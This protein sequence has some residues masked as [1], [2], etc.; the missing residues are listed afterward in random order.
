MSFAKP[1]SGAGATIESDV[2]VVGAGPA[3]STTAAYL[4][5]H[6][7][8]VTML[9]KSHFPREKVCGDGLTPRATR[10]LTRLGIDTSEANGWLHNKGLRVYGGRKEPF[11]LLWPDLTDFPPYGVVRPRADFDDMLAKHAV[12]AGAEL[13]Q[14][15]NV[16]GAILDDRTGRITGVTTKD[17]RSFSAPLVVAA[18][19]NSSRLSVSMGLNKR[20]DRPM[21]VAVRT[22]YTSPRTNDD[23]LESWLELWDG[24]PHKSTLMPGYGWVFGMG[25]GTSNVGLGVLNTSKGFGQTDYRALLKR[26]LDNT[27]EEWGF[28]DENMVGKVQGAALPMA[29]NR[30]PHYGR[31]L[32]L[33]G[34]AGGMVNPFNGE[35]IAYAMEAAEYAAEAIA[36]ANSRGF[37]T[38][39]AEKAMQAYPARLRAELGGYYRLGTIFVKL[40]GDPRIMKLCTTYGLPRK[41]L[42]RFVLKLLANLT[43]SHDGDAMDRII[44]ALCR[45]AP[46]A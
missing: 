12:A 7:L 29:F 24:E 40:I 43:D 45:V 4:A 42:M 11:E 34:D 6:G 32:V 27:P 14:G 8:S 19:G 20:A 25:D 38:R 46:S 39:S 13:V 9:E 23:F 44:N 15:A 5:R 37:G 2:I 3:G 41:T 30:Q 28:R 31:G 36:E 26:W 35:G 16:D 33:V 10:Q 21:G 1:Q 22:Y 18:D 17:G